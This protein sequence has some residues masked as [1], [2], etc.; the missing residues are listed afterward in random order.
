MVGAFA[1]GF[2][3]ARFGCF[4]GRSAAGFSTAAGGRDP[5]GTWILLSGTFATIAFLMTGDGPGA[6]VRSSVRG[7]A[8]GFG[9][10][11]AGVIFGDGTGEAA[12]MRPAEPGSGGGPARGAGAFGG[13]S[14]AAGVGRSDFPVPLSFTAWRSAFEARRTARNF[15][16]DGVRG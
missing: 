4:E 15:A 1:G 10:A 3:E 6:G 14:S 16:E 9:S 12:A 11:A 2:I 8:G 5:R 13:A 7:S